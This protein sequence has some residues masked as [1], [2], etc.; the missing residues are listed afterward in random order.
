MPANFTIV[1]AVAQNGIIGRDGQMP[2]HY[3]KDLEHFKE[4]TMGCPVIVGRK[5]FESIYDRI[6]SPLPGRTNIVLSRSDPEL[7]EDV[8]LASSIQEAKQKAAEHGSEAFVIGGA[9]IYEEFRP[10]VDRMIVTII[11]SRYE[12]DTQFPMWPPDEKT[13]TVADRSDHDE[14]S[15][16]TYERTEP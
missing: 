8:I 10:D 4:T 14:L 12:G 5:T 11:H 3:P 1:V 16:V 6:G 15:F 7:P 2:W 13:W 9:A